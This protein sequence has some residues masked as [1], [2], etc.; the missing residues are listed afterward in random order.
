MVVAVVVV[1]VVMV[2]VVTV[3]RGGGRGEGAAASRNFFFFLTPI[4]TGYQQ[5]GWPGQSDESL[6]HNIMDRFVQW[7]GNF[8]DTADA[9]GAGIS[10][11]II[12]NWLDK[13]TRENLVVATKCRFPMGRNVNSVGLS[14]R[15][16]T[17]SIDDSLRRLRTDYVD[18]YQ[19]HIFD[20]ATPIEETYRTLDDLVRCGKVRYVGVSNVSGWQLQKIVE[21]QKH[22]G[23]N[24]L[25]SLQQQYS[26]AARDS[27]LEVF[28]VC[29]NEGIGVLPWSPLKGGLLTGK[30]KRGEKPTEGRVGWVAK[31]E[32]RKLPSHPLWH[33]TPEKIFDTIDLAKKIGEKY[34][35]SIAQVAI[36]WLLQ[37]DVTTSVIIGAR[38]LEQLDQNMAVNDW[39]LTAEEMKQLDDLSTPNTPY[40]YD[41]INLV[42]PD[43]VNTYA[44]DYYVKSI[45]S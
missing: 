44:N 28:Q 39:S 35:R 43:R 1:L 32:S 38:T 26:L 33:E 19:T 45:A 16:I 25:V 15:H 10:E 13:Q 34:D 3:V 2:V 9:Y 42:N 11:T 41:M 22:L 24:P 37:R 27:E 4:I 30:V 21:T 12:G 20:N 5:M 6:A 8:I 36:R 23:L 29:K 31:D 18:L 17:Q 40:P 7:G 14:R